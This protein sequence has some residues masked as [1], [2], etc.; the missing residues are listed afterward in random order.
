MELK[1]QARI[2]TLYA[3]RF[4]QVL[5]EETD[6]AIRDFQEYLQETL[7]V[8]FEV[9]R[10]GKGAQLLPILRDA[11]NRNAREVEAKENA[12][13]QWT[14]KHRRLEKRYCELDDNLL[15]RNAAKKVLSDLH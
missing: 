9:P 1:N 14:Q 11:V 10:T 8:P 6:A 15:F 2:D 12:F 13:Q 4:F 7:P 5:I 3:D